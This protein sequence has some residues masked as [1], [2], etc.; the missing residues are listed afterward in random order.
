MQANEAVGGE[1]STTAA[2]IFY[3]TEHPLEYNSAEGKRSTLGE[4][5]GPGYVTAPSVLKS[6]SLH[7]SDAQGFR[8]HE[9]HEPLG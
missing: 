7:C 8:H 9:Q 6:A 1:P 3:G 4:H 2:E 5:S